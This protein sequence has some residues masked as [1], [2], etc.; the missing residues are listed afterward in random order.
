MKVRKD[1]IL[2]R[3]L[4]SGLDYLS[5]NA[6]MLNRLRV[7]RLQ[8]VHSQIRLFF[9]AYLYCQDAAARLG[10]FRQLQQN[11][12]LD[13]DIAPEDPANPFELAA[14]LC[15]SIYCQ[16]ASAEGRYCVSLTWKPAYRSASI[17]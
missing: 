3:V 16:A 15:R 10:G 4:R 12:S 7:I 8:D 17:T 9:A 2:V 13:G 14:V 6:K 1:S 11:I 5:T